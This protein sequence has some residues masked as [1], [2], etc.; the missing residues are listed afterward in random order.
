MKTHHLVAILASLFLCCQGTT[1]LADVLIEETFTNYLDNA[2]ISDSPAGSATGLMGDWSLP[3]NTDFYVNRTE[4]DLTAGTGKAVYDVNQDY[5]STREATRSTSAEHVLYQNS[6]DRFYASFLIDP[7]LVNGQMM[8]GLG[9]NQLD[10]G[11]TKGFAFGIIGGQYAVGTSD[12]RI[13]AADG[14]V[15][16][17]EQLVLVRIEYG[18]GVDENEN[19]TLWVDPLNESSVPVIDGVSADFLNAGGGKITSVS[20]RGAQM[21]GAPAFFDDLRVGTTFASVVPEPGTLTLC[22]LVCIAL[23]PLLRRRR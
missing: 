16:L 10:S 12:G 2:L 4:A 21:G 14:S 11:G 17:G 13:A 9:L 6:G 5:N 22:A 15:T 19:I 20:M 8:F 18:A 7:A 3:T 23:I 1:C